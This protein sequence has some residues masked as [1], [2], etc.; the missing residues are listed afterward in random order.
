M[1]P[2]TR[3]ENRLEALRQKASSLTPYKQKITNHAIEKLSELIDLY[4]CRKRKTE[5]DRLEDLYACFTDEFDI[6]YTDIIEKIE[7]GGE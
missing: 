7:G 1:I 6:I 5:K 3:A 4:T 2:I